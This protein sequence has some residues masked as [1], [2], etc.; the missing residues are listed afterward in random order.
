MHPKF[1]PAG[2]RTPDLQIMDSIFHVHETLVWTTD[3]IRD[4][5]KYMFFVVFEPFCQLSL[6]TFHHHMIQAVRKIYSV[7][8]I[9]AS[10]C[11]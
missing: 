8:D 9:D 6:C 10:Y 3:P 2:I 5:N 7:T 4:L 1:Y 11:H